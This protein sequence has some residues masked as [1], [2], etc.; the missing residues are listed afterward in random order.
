MNTD[1]PHPDG[2]VFFVTYLAKCSLAWEHV[3]LEHTFSNGKTRRL[4]MMGMSWTLSRCL[5]SDDGELPP[6]LLPKLQE[7]TYSG[8]GNIGDALAFALLIDVCQSA[9]PIA[10]IHRWNSPG[11]IYHYLTPVIQ[12]PRPFS[13]PVRSRDS[14]YPQLYRTLWTYICTVYM[15]IRFAWLYTGI[16]IS[17]TRQ[18][19]LSL[20]VFTPSSLQKREVDSSV[21][22]QLRIG[23]YIHRTRR[24]NRKRIHESLGKISGRS[25]AIEAM[26]IM[27][28]ICPPKVRTRRQGGALVCHVVPHCDESVFPRSTMQTCVQSLFHILLLRTQTHTLSSPILSPHLLKRLDSSPR[29]SPTV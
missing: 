6:D 29:Q 10:L 3:T 19:G 23:V 13:L 2:L 14:K 8:S 24:K 15:R 18:T 16:W 5:R 17:T 12:R 26:N 25:S 20:R 27:N 1:Y 22:G 21:T 4:Y 28:S 11:L 7:L 9:G